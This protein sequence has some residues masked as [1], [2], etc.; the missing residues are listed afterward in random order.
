M[1]RVLFEED[2]I[3]AL[4]KFIDSY[5]STF[6]RMIEDSGLDVEDYLIENYIQIWNKLYESVIWEIKNNF[7][8]EILFWRNKDF[9]IININNFRIFVY[10]EENILKRERYI[11]K[12]EFFKK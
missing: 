4:K 10:F 5:K 11:T 6:V 8:Q 7:S 9:L 1:F 12:I 2:A 3:D